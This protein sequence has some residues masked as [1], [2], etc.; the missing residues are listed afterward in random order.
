M[1]NELQRIEPS[2]SLAAPLAE[3]EILERLNFVK[4]VMASAMVDGQDYGKVPGCGDKPS[5]F[6]PGAQKL[7]LTFQLSEAVHHEVKTDLPND[8]REYEFVIRV[9]HPGGKFADGVGTCGTKE[10]K[11]RYRGGER[12][13]PVCGKPSIITGKKEFGGGF[14]CFTKKGGCG[15]KFSDNDPA[16]TGQQIGRVEHDNPADFYN[17]VRK[18][19]FKRALVHATINFTNTSELWSQDLEDIAENTRHEPLPPVNNNMAGREQKNA[20]PANV[21]RKQAAPVNG[22]KVKARFLEL[23]RPLAKQAKAY[24]EEKGW[25]APFDLLTDWPLE[26]V[27]NSKAALLELQRQI[28]AFAG[29]PDMPNEGGSSE[30]QTGLPADIANVIWHVPPKGVKK[31]DYTPETIGKLYADRHTTETANRLFGFIEHFAANGWTKDDGT[32]VAPSQHDLDLRAGLDKL[33]A[34]LETHKD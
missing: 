3:N 10:G 26:H 12:K 21:E 6:Q 20:A 33:S 30:P 29:T 17:T 5:L 22:D 32:K 31:K 24:A 25:L 34:W 23:I 4:R 28:E 8:H 2:G 27:P 18:M 19:A 13:C 7:L 11:Y 15:A 9:S 14:I 16:I 1:S